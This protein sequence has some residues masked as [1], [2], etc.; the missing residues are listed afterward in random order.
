MEYR[1][2][3]ADLMRERFGPKKDRDQPVRYTA[4]ASLAGTMAGLLTEDDFAT[5]LQAA[6]CGE[7]DS[8]RRGPY[9]AFTRS[10]VDHFARELRTNLGELDATEGRQEAWHIMLALHGILPPDL[11]S[12]FIR[13]ANDAWENTMEAT[14]RALARA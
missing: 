9:W 10:F 5:F 4:A 2:E 3:L 8:H 13:C 11:F 6:L 1:D 7:R 14:G 12:P